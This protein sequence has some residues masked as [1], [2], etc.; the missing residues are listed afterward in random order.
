MDWNKY[1]EDFL[2]KAKNQKKDKKYCDK[3]LSYAHNLYEQELPIIYN[4]EHFCKLVGYMPEYVYAASNSADHFYRTFFI[5]KKKCRHPVYVLFFKFY[6]QCLV[7]D[8]PQK[9]RR[10]EKNL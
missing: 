3:W 4:Q 6:N 10:I 1:R 7:P 2:I 9:E 5:P 8:H